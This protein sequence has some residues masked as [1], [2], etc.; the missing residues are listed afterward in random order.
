MIKKG[1]RWR[2]GN[3]RQIHIWEDKW[4][5]TPTSHKVITPQTDFDDYPMVSSLIDNDTRWWKVEV[6][7]SIFLP[8]EASTI[9]KIPLNYNLLED[10]L[11]WLGNKR[12][13]FTVK[14]AYHI[15]SNLVDSSEDGECSSSDSKTLL[16]K[17]IWSQKVPQKLKIFAWRTCV[18]GL[19]TM[20]NLSH[21]GIHC[22]S[23][24]PL[25]DKAIESTAHA[26][27]LCDH[28]K[29]SWA[30]WHN[31][32]VEVTSS[33]SEPIDI[34][35][36]IIDKGSPSDLELFFTVAWSIWWNHNQ[37][38]HEDSGTPPSQV[39]EM[40]NIFLG[41]YKD[42]CSLPIFSPAPAPTTWQAPPLGFFKINVDG[43]ALDDGKPSCIG[44]VIHDCRG[45]LIAASNKI[46]PTP[47]SVEITEAT[48]LQE[49]VLLA[50]EM[51][52]SHVLVESN[53]LSVIQAIIECDLGGELGHIIQNIKDISSSFSWCSF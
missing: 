13:V 5:P 41:E 31:C 14:S 26:L 18:N 16:W 30:Q 53:A 3:G 39:W 12:G 51:G 22:S 37:V 32:L 35:L 25:C 19:P 33:S 34:A 49:G 6:V 48:A 29:L 21:R 15:T 1:T 27:F 46:L 52:I 9:L 8:S 4:L 10:S 36:D 50:S 44:V 7:R 40:A 42:A 11:I 2:V 45:F 38:V 23:F 20:F 28:A 17:R 24:C 43:A 47:I